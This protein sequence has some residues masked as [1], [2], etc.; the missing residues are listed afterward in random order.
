[1]SGRGGGEE[2]DMLVTT[3]VV[4]VGNV[5]HSVPVKY[6]RPEWRSTLHLKLVLIST[7]VM[8][9]KCCGLHAMLPPLP[10]AG[11]VLLKTYGPS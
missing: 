6:A 1:V 3:E 5:H 7:S 8:L 9:D 2:W 4:S 11:M 10:I